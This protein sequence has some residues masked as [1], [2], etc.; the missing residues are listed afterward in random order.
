MAIEIDG[1]SKKANIDGILSNPALLLD[2]SGPPPQIYT[3]RE[4]SARLRISARTLQKTIQR[5]RDEGHTIG[6]NN[7]GATTTTILT[8]SDAERI[9]DWRNRHKPGRPPLS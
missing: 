8:E 6:L 2:E 4:L 9:R 3:V 5:M 1:A 7:N